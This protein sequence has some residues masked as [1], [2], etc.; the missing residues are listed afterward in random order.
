MKFKIPRRKGNFGKVNVRHEK[1]GNEN[2][3]AADVKFS[4]NGTKT[5][6]DMLCPLAN[7][8]KFSDT[9]WDEHGNLMVPY[10]SPLPNQR[11]PD[12]VNFTVWDKT[13]P[14]KF[15][16]VRLKSLVIELHDKRN[17]TLHGM[18]QIHDDPEKHSF[19]LRS[20]MDSVHEFTLEAAQED[21]YEEEPVEDPEE[22]QGS[23]A[24]TTE[25]P[26]DEVEE[27]EDDE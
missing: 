1:H 8:E 13:S 20:L 18:I 6:L 16:D 27:E 11:T 5:T 9:V 10:L 19:R 22:P 21:F 17:I 12:N 26:D 23:L 4:C 2:I 24:V 25:Q 7:G 3:P 15:S 14:L